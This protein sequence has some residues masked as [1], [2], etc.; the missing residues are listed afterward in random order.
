MEIS[1][2]FISKHIPKSVMLSF[3]IYELFKEG[4]SNFYIFCYWFL[5][6]LHDGRII[7]F[8]QSNFLTLAKDCSSLSMW[9]IFINVPSVFEKNMVYP[10]PWRNVLEIPIKWS[11]QFHNSLLYPHRFFFSFF[12][13]LAA[14][15]IW[16]AEW[17]MLDMGKTGDKRPAKLMTNPEGRMFSRTIA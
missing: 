6:E 16:V 13:F 3:F 1:L 11:L 5:L 12:F 17:G 15:S 7:L 9:S 8:A 14:C 2:L 10:V 4:F